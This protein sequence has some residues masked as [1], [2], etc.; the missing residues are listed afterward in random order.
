MLARTIICLLALACIMAG[1]GASAYSDTLNSLSGGTIVST[2]EI[3]G[4]SNVSMTVWYPFSGAEINSSKLKMD[5][6]KRYV[7]L[8][9]EQKTGD[10]LI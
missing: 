2:M 6:G 5:P 8:V 10:R 9:V 7:I 4:A 1:A 3:I